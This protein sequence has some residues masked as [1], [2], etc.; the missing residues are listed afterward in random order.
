MMANPWML[1]A[2]ALAIVAVLIVTHWNTVK[3]ATAAAWH[4][5]VDKVKTGAHGVMA[6]I[7]FLASLPGKVGGY[8]GRMKDAAVSKAMALVGWVKGLPGRIRSAVGNL[9]GLLVGAGRSVVTGLWHGIE[10]MGGWLW[11]QIMGW[12][13]RVVPGPILHFLGIHSPSRLAASW[14]VNV[15]EGLA[16]GIIS[17][18]SMVE[19]ASGDLAGK[20]A[21]PGSASVTAARSSGA[22]VNNRGGVARLVIDLRGGDREMRKMVR[23]WIR[24]GGGDVQTVMGP[25]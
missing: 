25:A 3:K 4:W 14:G 6:A 19:R 22:R 18:G 17:G 20:V 1:L 21:G 16:Q 9:G 10:A 7:G 5:V 8:F 12:I 23:K 11:G 2:V 13:R 24:D 15:A